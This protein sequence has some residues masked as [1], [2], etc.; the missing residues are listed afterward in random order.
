MRTHCR[1]PCTALSL[2]LP[3]CQPGNA[4]MTALALVQPARCCCTAEKPLCGHHRV[5][6]SVR[7]TFDP[8]KRPLSSDHC[9]SAPPRR[10]CFSITHFST[11]CSYRLQ[12]PNSGLIIVSILFPASP[13]LSQMQTLQQTPGAQTRTVRSS[14]PLHSCVA[15]QAARLTTNPRQHST[16]ADLV[17][18]QP[19]RR[20]LAQAAAN[21]SCLTTPVVCR[22]APDAN[23]AVQESLQGKAAHTLS[24][25]TCSHTSALHLH[26][27]TPSHF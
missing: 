20:V 1:R 19:C 26:P 7:C 4:V 25:V 10:G 13:C 23:V 2:H 22:A 5:L 3:M 15:V 21:N 24:C 12:V 8:C 27:C 14:H 16:T 9:P 17:S 11:R 6:V 18:F